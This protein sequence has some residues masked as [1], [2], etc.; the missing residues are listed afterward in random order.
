MPASPAKD[1]LGHG[2]LS[3]VHRFAGQEAVQILGQFAGRGIAL[4]GVV[5]EAGRDHGLQIARDAGHAPA[6]GD[7]LFVEERD[8]HL[9]LR[10]AVV[11]EA[12]RK[13]LV[14][15]HAEAEDVAASVEGAVLAPGL[16][17]REVSRGPQHL[18]GDGDARDRLLAGDSEIQHVGPKI[19]IGGL[20]HH[21]VSRLQ[22]T[23][24]Q[25]LAVGRL[26]GLGDLLDQTHLAFQR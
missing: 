19:A 21:D 26:D 11:G 25:S 7:R 23:M 14:Q 16:L 1:L 6:Q 8:E 20:A 18:T 5:L 2:H 22:V 9:D 13:Q 17:R 4:V 12:S 15:D 3:G 10:G 24:D